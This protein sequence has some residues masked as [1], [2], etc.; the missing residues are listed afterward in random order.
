MCFFLCLKALTTSIHNMFKVKQHS[1]I[2]W[3]KISYFPFLL[4][5]LLKLFRF[6][7]LLNGVGQKGHQLP[8]S[9]F[10]TS[11]IDSS[12]SLRNQFDKVENDL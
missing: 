2:F 9:F 6:V 12:L 10:D 3:T 8:S 4:I 1:S 5:L 11:L 7:L